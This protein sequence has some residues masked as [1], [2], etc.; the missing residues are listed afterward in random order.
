MPIKSMVQEQTEIIAKP[1][2]LD[3]VDQRNAKI[4]VKY[5]NT[6]IKSGAS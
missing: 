2:T 3:R 5:Q 4:L 6:V 1:M